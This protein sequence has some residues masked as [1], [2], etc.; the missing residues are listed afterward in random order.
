MGAF[1]FCYAL[2]PVGQYGLV[3]RYVALLHTR[4]YRPI[5]RWAIR[6]WVAL[7]PVGQYALLARLCAHFRC[8][9]TPRVAPPP[10]PLPIGAGELNPAI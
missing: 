5:A 6:A 3:S 2:L 10:T 4:F 9:H 8:A 7:L 1:G